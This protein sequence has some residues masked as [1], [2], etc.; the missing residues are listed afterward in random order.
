MAE[1]SEAPDE[2]A[3]A[4]ELSPDAREG[5]QSLG[6]LGSWPVAVLEVGKNL[7]D[8]KDCMADRPAG[9]RKR[10]ET[11]QDLAASSGA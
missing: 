8:P 1:E 11:R 7:P 6:Y 3:P 4:D 5:L 10:K 9:F 2:L